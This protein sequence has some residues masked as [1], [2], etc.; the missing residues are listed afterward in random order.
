MSSRSPGANV[1][2]RLFRSQ[3]RV[4]VYVHDQQFHLQRCVRGSG[5]GRNFALDSYPLTFSARLHL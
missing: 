5:R 4:H 2:D 3:L 1:H